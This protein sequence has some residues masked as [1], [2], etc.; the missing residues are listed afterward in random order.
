MKNSYARILNHTS[1]PCIHHMHRMRRF[2]F[3]NGTAG[4]SIPGENYDYEQDTPLFY[5]CSHHPELLILPFLYQP[6]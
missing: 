2:S 3:T 5:D 4:N 6:L 1:I